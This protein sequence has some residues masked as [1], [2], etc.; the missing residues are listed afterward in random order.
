MAS[1]R[2]A[3]IQPFRPETSVPARLGGREEEDH[4]SVIN[5]NGEQ[6]VVV[7]QLLKAL[8]P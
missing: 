1:G 2:L 6:T 4:L 8:Q 7:H 5:P 3:L